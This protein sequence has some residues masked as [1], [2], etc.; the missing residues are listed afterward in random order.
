LASD[1]HGSYRGVSCRPAWSSPGNLTRSSLSFRL[2]QKIFA[3]R[4]VAFGVPPHLEIIFKRGQR[5]IPSH[6]S[7]GSVADPIMSPIQL[8][9]AYFSKTFNDV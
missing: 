4:S 7:S 8:S 3:N 9:P 2:R 6:M 1:G 5:S